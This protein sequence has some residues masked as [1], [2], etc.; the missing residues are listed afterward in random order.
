MVGMV[1]TDL[2]QASVLKIEV[3]CWPK[4]M[5]LTA[6]FGRNDA[7]KNIFLRPHASVAE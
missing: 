2:S 5:E 3:P 7:M 4:R 1:P 6:L